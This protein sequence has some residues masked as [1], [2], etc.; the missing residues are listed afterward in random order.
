MGD[1]N[2]YVGVTPGDL[3]S[4]HACTDEADWEVWEDLVIHLPP[5][6]SKDPSR[7]NNNW[8]CK[9][10]DFCGK[11]NLI[12]LKGRVGKDGGVENF[13]YLIQA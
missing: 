12:I 1:F 7:R 11:A 9:I 4:P 13:T 2:V 8:G 5:R 6:A 3:M 10:L